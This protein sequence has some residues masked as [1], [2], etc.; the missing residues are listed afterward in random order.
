MQRN[1]AL[2]R[3]YTEHNCVAAHLHRLLI[4][5][6]PHCI[7]C[8]DPNSTMDTDH[9]LQYQ[10]IQK[11]KSDTDLQLNVKECKKVNG[12]HPRT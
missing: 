11:I 1:V 12:G 5:P 3:L 10:A 4:L 8:K 9:L 2:F 6:H 7:L